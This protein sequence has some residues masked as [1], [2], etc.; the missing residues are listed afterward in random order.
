MESV[1]VDA[2]PLHHMIREI[3]EQPKGLAETLAV[4]FRDAEGLLNSF[5][6]RKLEWCISL[7][8]AQVITLA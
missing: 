3:Y 6:P 8:V 5:I 7:E 2:R 4:C 1:E